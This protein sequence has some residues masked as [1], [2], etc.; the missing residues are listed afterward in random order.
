MRPDVVQAI[1]LLGIASYT[2][3]VSGFFLMQYVTVTPRV[4]A[5]LRSIPV[6]LTGAIV[7]PIGFNGG[8]AEWLGFAVT[9]VLMRLTANEFLSAIGAVLVVALARALLP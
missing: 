5:W 6:A 3:R 2:C 9:V 8:P 1:L 7:A 4:K